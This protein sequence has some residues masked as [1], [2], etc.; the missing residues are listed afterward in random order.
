MSLTSD[1][2]SDLNLRSFMAVTAHWMARG[3]TNQLE[4]RS[5]LIAFREVDGCHAGYNLGQYLF[6][7]IQDTGIAHKVCVYHT[8][9]HKK[10]ADLSVDWP[11]HA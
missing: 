4:L 2:W 3:K 9:T 5:A 1:L 10:H 11:D 7:I 8:L 6:D